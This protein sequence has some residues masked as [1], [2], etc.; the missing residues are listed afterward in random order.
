MS[1][2]VFI[3]HETAPQAAIWTAWPSHAELWEENLAPA[4]AQ[5]AAMIQALAGPATDRET[6]ERIFVLVRGDQ[7]RRSALAM[8]G[9]AAT[10]LDAEFGD[11]WLRDT[12][13]VFAWRGDRRVALRPGFNGW[14]GKYGLPGDGQI[15]AHIANLIETPMEPVDLVIEGGALE[16][17]GEGT[18]LTTRECVLNPN[19]NP[20]L[21]EAEAERR[22]KSAFGVET[23]LW[24]DR[25][26]INDHTDGH[27]DN[28]A[29][30]LGGGRAL[31]QTPFGDDDPHRERLE[32]A[33][34]QLSAMT[35]ARGRRLEV[36]TIPSPGR[37][38]G[39]DGEA[40]PASHLNYVIG[41]RAVVVPVYGTNSQGEAVSILSELFP[42]RFVAGRAATALLTGGGAFH[43]VTQHQPEAPQ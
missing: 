13:P 12:G 43:C 17:D 42:D 21:T 2:P 22:L 18:L 23:V 31:C 5:M 35:D 28:I 40:C 34:E 15:G 4:Q 41:N 30:L 25:G 39:P 19:R 20:G 14:G 24:L 33:R 10:V 38:T 16:F 36:I 11:I 6:P 1:T 32:A 8:V 26:L 7:A 29:R 27:I 37:V 3:P 9:D